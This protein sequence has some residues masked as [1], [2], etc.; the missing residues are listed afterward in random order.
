MKL[1]MR[2]FGFVTALITL[3]GIS[4]RRPCAGRV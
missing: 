3:F 1:K 2:T 4:L